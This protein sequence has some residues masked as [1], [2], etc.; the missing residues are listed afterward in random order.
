MTHQPEVEEASSTTP[1]A[2]LYSM[3]NSSVEYSF[4]N[5]RNKHKTAGSFGNI[6]NSSPLRE[7]PKSENKISDLDSDPKKRLGITIEPPAISQ[8][9]QNILI[10]DKLFRKAN[11]YRSETDP[12]QR[13]RSP[14][15]HLEQGFHKPQFNI[16]QS[17][18]K[19]TKNRPLITLS[20]ESRKISV[21]N[22]RLHRT[23]ETQKSCSTRRTSQNDVKS[24]LAKFQ[25]TPRSKEKKTEDLEKNKKS[26]IAKAQISKLGISQLIEAS[27]Q[28]TEEQK[29]VERKKQVSAFLQGFQKSA[30]G[31]PKLLMKPKLR[32][33][34]LPDTCDKQSKFKSVRKELS[35][36]SIRDPKPE[37]NKIKP[38][39]RPPA[40]SSTL[41]HLQLLTSRTKAPEPSGS[42]A[43]PRESK[44]NT[45]EGKRRNVGI[46]KFYNFLKKT[47]KS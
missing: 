31:V 19:S 34:S 6:L 11:V 7:D 38:L 43:K 32:D 14:K 39:L 8:D 35:L 45:S 27:K 5:N 15:P 28:R 2:A 36:T 18:P 33:S 46:D 42:R 20:S 29:K 1:R 16:F 9:S 40:Y 37:S 30:L 3:N 25:I 22:S 12:T 26:L 47:T 23:I 13:K 24:L 4:D 21:D 41:D 44:S 17:I 10:V